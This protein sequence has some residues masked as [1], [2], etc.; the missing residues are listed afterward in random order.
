MQTRQRSIL[1]KFIFTSAVFKRHSYTINTVTITS[2]GISICYLDI[3]YTPKL[4]KR[5][6]SLSVE[7][8]LF[9]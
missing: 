5:G 2:N 6:G 9:F 7:G 4:E 8:L 3:W 1:V